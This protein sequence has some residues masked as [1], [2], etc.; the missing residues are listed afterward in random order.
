MKNLLII[1]LIAIIAS[2]ASAQQPA[3][4]DSILILLPGR[5]HQGEISS[6]LAGDDWFGLYDI[7]N[8]YRLLKTEVTIDTCEDP[9]AGSRTGLCVSI[10]NSFD[11]VI[12]I[13][14]LMGL[15]EGPVQF[16]DT[17]RKFLYPGQSFNIKPSI[18]SQPNFVLVSQANITYEEQTDSGVVF[19]QPSDPQLIDYELLIGVGNSRDYQV[20]F[21]CPWAGLDAYPQLIWAGHIDRDGKADLL[22]NL[23]CHPSLT[24]CSLFLSSLG[25]DDEYLKKA[26]ELR[27]VAD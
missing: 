22:M 18:G 4:D 17:G 14:G 24:N 26:A 19:R 1:S 5:Y 10:D 12:L 7:K 6:S 3:S 9:S 2:L 15:K 21:S 20:L 13:R 25:S 8:E 23:T 27:G 11:P 16:L